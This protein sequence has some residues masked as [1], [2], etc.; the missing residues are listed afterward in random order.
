MPQPRQHQIWAVFVNCATA[1]S[2]A[3]SLTHLTHE[4]SWT[5]FWVLNPLSHNGNS[6]GIIS[7]FISPF[8][9]WLS[10]LMSYS[11][12][13]NSDMLTSILLCSETG[14]FSYLDLFETKVGKSTISPRPN[15]WLNFFI[16]FQDKE[17]WERLLSRLWRGNATSH[18]WEPH[19][20]HTYYLKQ[21]FSHC[22][23]Y[24]KV[25]VVNFF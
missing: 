8:Y 16:D 17:S 21:S 18:Q 24:Q 22:L 4:S 3:R 10:I 13:L 2:N 11:T 12:S 25:D 5:P 15:I 19:S 9:L 6:L 23:W 14:I 20:H 7:R 1:C